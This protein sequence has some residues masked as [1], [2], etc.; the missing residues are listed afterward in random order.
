MTEEEARSLLLGS[1][2]HTVRVTC[3]DATNIPRSRNVPVRR[4]LETGVR[5]G[6]QYPSAMF[7]VD[8][9][10]DFVPAASAGFE[11]GYPSLVLRPDLDTL[12]VLPWAEGVARVICDVE[13]IEG[14]PLAVSPRRVLRRVLE[15]AAQQGYAV[16]AVF[17]YEFYVLRS[18][19][20]SLEPSWSG[21]N[22]YADAVHIQVSDILDQ[23]S[24]GL[25]AIGAEVYEAN[26]EYGPGQFEITTRPFDGLEAADMALHY[27]LAVK[28]I[29][30]RLGYLATFMTKPISDASAS[31]AHLHHS[32]W[33]A[34][35]ANAFDGPDAE[36]GLSPA[37]R[38]FVAGELEHLDAIAA[39]AAPSVNSYKRL[40]PYT[41]APANHTWG[42]ENRM[43]AIRVPGARGS[44]THLENR[45][46]GADCNPHLTLAA[47]VGAG[48]EGMRQGLEP[49]VLV[50][51]RDAY[52]EPAPPVPDSLGMALDAL[53]NDQTMRA[54]MGEDF[55]RTY[56]ALKRH[57][58]S[59]FE[60]HVTDWEVAEYLELL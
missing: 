51:E 11:S 17:E 22:S 49:P 19:K 44:G 50:A 16:K 4:F 36:L 8:T 29:C 7:S 54:V 35:P 25:S 31:G 46:P 40:R 53:Q 21:H 41:F 37:C 6:I 27:R 3:A 34:G 9:S 39:V 2:V 18:A 28:E 5:A 59:R 38:S 43:C 10:C 13:D 45:L 55:V 42:L 30:H 58:I 23:L 14:R 47:V 56:V 48:I 52:A 12:R 20:P 26:T 15:S 1:G 33:T 24:R 57:E 32:L 60:A